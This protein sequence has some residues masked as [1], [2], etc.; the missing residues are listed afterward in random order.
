MNPVSS[1]T[2]LTYSL[3]TLPDPLQ[4][5]PAQGNVV[6]AGL[7]LIVSNSGSTI[8]NLSQL[9]VTVPVGTLAQ[10]L[11]TNPGAILWSTSPS[12]LWS[13]TMTSPGVFLLVPQSGS[14][15]PVS[16]EG[17]V[18]QFYNIPV[19]PQVGAVS[20][21]V[22]ETASNTSAPA[23]VYTATFSVAK[24]PY[25][26]YFT[27][28]VSQV[29]MVQVG[30]PVTLTWQGSDNATY[31]MQWSAAPAVDVTN[32]RSWVSPNLTS[33][34]TFILQATVVSQGETVLTSFS[35]TV[36]VAS[37]ELQ[38]TTLQVA[39][40]SN[41]QGATTIGTGNTQATINGNLTVNTATISGALTS[42]TSTTKQLQASTLT[43]NQ[44]STLNNTS[45]S[46]TTA[47]QGSVT[48][49]GTSQTLY[50]GSGTGANGPNWA[51]Y[52]ST[53]DGFVVGT[54]LSMPQNGNLG[55]GVL[56]CMCNGQTAY[57]TGGMSG[58][59]TLAQLSTTLTMPV[60][61]NTPFYLLTT[62]VDSNPAAPGDAGLMC[63]YIPFGTGTLTGP[64]TATIDAANIVVPTV[65]DL[66]R[67]QEAPAKLVAM[68]ESLLAQ[69][70][71]PLVKQQMIE[72]LQAMY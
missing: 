23:Q 59:Y 39:G 28:F 48:A 14:P 16:I 52:S 29:P 22:N 31:A 13:V 67:K 4:A 5:T 32:V 54:M 37:P 42:S 2:L 46:G 40:A 41:L 70:M 25:G 51:Q 53:T 1:N 7:S 12:T 72:L 45:L 68:F 9:E 24:F 58:N 35:T 64:S 26:F 19:N 55:I 62:W 36:I 49:L 66:L 18:I 6:Y 65:P 50:P 33:D 15:I 8:V 27:N 20:I 38:A 60:P 44:S 17:M 10:D 3:N 61:A 34:T 47:L 56:L 69:R 43:V 11:T 57:A 63:N 71:D 30:S 21:N